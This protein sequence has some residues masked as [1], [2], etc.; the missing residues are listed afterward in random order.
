MNFNDIFIVFSETSHIIYN[1]IYIY[2]NHI[3][4][5]TCETLT[6]G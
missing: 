3:H 5:A 2:A 1:I 4:A 6:S